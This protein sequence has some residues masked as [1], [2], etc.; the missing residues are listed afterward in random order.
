MDDLSKVE[1][2]PDPATEQSTWRYKKLM[3][4][5]DLIFMDNCSRAGKKLSSREN[6]E[7][8]RIQMR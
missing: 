7:I 2:M 8:I 5:F 1:F 4:D 3:T 6:M